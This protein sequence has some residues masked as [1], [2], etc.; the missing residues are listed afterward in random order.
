MAAAAPA[1][2][3]PAAPAVPPMRRAATQWN[4][5]ASMCR[6]SSAR[7]TVRISDHSA[8]P[9]RPR[10]QC[11]TLFGRHS[12]SSRSSLHTLQLSPRLLRQR[13]TRMLRGLH[14][15]SVVGARG[16]VAPSMR[17]C[18]ADRR[19]PVFDQRQDGRNR[20]TGQARDDAPEHDTRALRWSCQ[21]PVEIAALSC[22]HICCDMNTGG[23]GAGSRRAGVVPHE[24]DQPDDGTVR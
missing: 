2:P 23:M 15:K 10:R 11:S 19:G 8:R 1:L 22:I 12:R 7:P 5:Q 9:S 14:C 20:M 17:A 3:P 16:F 6:M 13:P 21:R 4:V 24:P 18:C